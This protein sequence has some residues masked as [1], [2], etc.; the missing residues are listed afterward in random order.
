MR[1]EPQFTNG[2]SAVIDPGICPRPEAAGPDL[3][4]NRARLRRIT[5]VLL[6]P[7]DDFGALA[8]AIDE[9]Y[10]LLLA[11]SGLEPDREANRTDLHLN[12]GKA[13]GPSW[14]AF[15]VREILRTKRF[16]R[17]LHEGIRAAQNRFPGQTIQVLYAGTGPFATLALPLTTI[18]SSAEVNFTLLEINPE[19]LKSLPRVLAAF[20]AER[21][22]R[23]IS[24]ADATVYQADRNQPLHLVV[25]E[26]MQNA[27]KKGPQVPVAPD[28]PRSW[29]FPPVEVE[30]PKGLPARFTQLALLTTIQ[31]F[32]PERLTPWQCSLTLPH[33]VLEL[34]GPEPAGAGLRFQYQVSDNP[35]FQ[36]RT[37]TGGMA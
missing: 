17:G 20:G 28:E 32:G 30:I 18:F 5:D 26:T 16:V 36:W 21:H 4:A 29:A 13:I 22:V 11:V 37:L 10:R 35:G 33:R 31:V 19:S 27:L 7:E 8:P 2:V 23:A 14:A 12:R 25:T 3:D 34:N 24:G 6:Q 9:L 1:S 15:C